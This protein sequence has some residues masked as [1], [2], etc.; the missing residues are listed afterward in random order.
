MHLQQT[1]ALQT[2][3]NIVKNS[4]KCCSQLCSF[5]GSMGPS[6]GDFLNKQVSRLECTRRI[7]F[8]IFGEAGTIV[9][10][11]S[12]PRNGWTIGLQG[13]QNKKPQESQYKVAGPG[14]SSQN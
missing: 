11:L 13:S 2:R 3:Q 9:C 10:S 4:S 5:D 14:F 8:D 6:S 12:G 7:N 1:A